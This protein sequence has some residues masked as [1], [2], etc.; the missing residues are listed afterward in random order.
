MP[1]ALVAKL[2]PLALPAIQRVDTLEGL[3]F[4]AA[5]VAE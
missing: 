3:A 1:R 5:E 2:E 4:P